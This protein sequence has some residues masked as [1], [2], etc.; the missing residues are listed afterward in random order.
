M[1]TLTPVNR[2][3][4]PRFANTPA[5]GELGTVGVPSAEGVFVAGLSPGCE[6]AIGLLKPKL[7]IKP[8]DMAIRGCS[9]SG[10]GDGGGVEKGF[11]TSS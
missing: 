4:S 6:E 11:A 7:D 5:L 1:K 9:G 10:V 2:G 3:L 8:A